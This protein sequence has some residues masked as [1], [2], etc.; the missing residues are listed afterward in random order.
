MNKLIIRLLLIILS[1]D[2]SASRFNITQA[3][4]RLGTDE[5]TVTDSVIRGCRGANQGAQEN[6]DNVCQLD[7]RELVR[8]EAENIPASSLFIGYLLVKFDCV[9]DPALSGDENSRN[10]AGANYGNQLKIF[11]GSGETILEDPIN[12]YIFPGSRQEV[13]AG[14]IGVISAVTTSA[15]SLIV[16]N[17][18]FP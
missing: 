7:V 16:Y 17:W 14:F 2:A 10:I 11:C 1:I 3:T 13:A 5:Y 15:L 12:T 18:I 9:A 8:L 6:I 4:Y